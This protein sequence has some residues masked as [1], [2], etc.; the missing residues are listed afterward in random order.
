MDKSEQVP[1]IDLAR[2]IARQGE[3]RL[4]ATI[5]L[6]IAADMRAATVGGILGA[7]A[8]A[9][10][11][12]VLAHWISG[13]SQPEMIWAGSGVSALLFVAMV[14]CLLSARASSFM[15]PGGEPQAWRA[16]ALVRN[17]WCGE[18]EL[19]DAT[20]LRYDES[21]NENRKQLSRNGRLFNWA[22]ILFGLALP[23]GLTFFFLGARIVRLFS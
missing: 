9:V 2:E 12:A 7:T 22:L 21:I 5:A 17:Q 4:G 6:G 16:W 20:A 15:A 11:G 18:A 23:S 19:L 8:T 13:Q 1:P 10:T 3:V 14:L